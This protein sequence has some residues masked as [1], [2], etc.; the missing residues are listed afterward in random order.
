MKEQGAEANGKQLWKEN[1]VDLSHQPPELLKIFEFFFFN[2]DNRTNNT[3]IDGAGEEGESFM[4]DWLTGL[5]RLRRP[6]I[7]HVQTEAQ[8]GFRT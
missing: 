7:C 1:K 4:R 8:E 3:D 5:W 2:W 6:R